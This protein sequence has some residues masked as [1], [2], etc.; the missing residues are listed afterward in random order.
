MSEFIANIKARLNTSEIP[1]DIK[2]IEGQPVKLNNVT[3]DPT[4]ISSMVKQIQA[5]LNNAKFSLP[6]LSPQMQQQGA[7]SGKQFANAFTSQLNTIAIKNNG[8]IGITKALQDFGYDTKSISSITKKLQDLDVAT[9][10]LQIRARGNGLMD[11]RIKGVDELGRS[12][13]ETRRFVNG[14]EDAERRVTST[15]QKFGASASQLKTMGKI[16]FGIE[17]NSFKAEIDSIVQDAHKLTTVSQDIDYNRYELQK[18]FNTMTNKGE[19]IDVRIEAYERFNQLLPIV[20][21]QLIDAANAEQTLTQ[22]STKILQIKEWMEKNSAATE[23][24]GNELNSIL[25]KLNGNSDS[26]VLKDVDT[27]FRNIQ[28]QAEALKTSVSSVSQVNAALSN[29]SV[30][31]SISDTEQKFRSLQST[32]NSLNSSSIG[33]GIKINVT[34]IE[35]QFKE[36]AR[37]SA[38]LSGGKLSDSAMVTK[39]NELQSVL[40]AVRNNISITANDVSKLADKERDAATAAETLS[41]STTLLSQVQSWSDNNAVAAEHFRRE[42]DE[43]TNKLHGNSDPALLKN[44][45]LQFNEIKAK[46]KELELDTISLKRVMSDLDG[47]TT[48]VSKIAKSISDA[49]TKFQ[50]LKTTIS[51]FKSAK[52]DSGIESQITG[53]TNGLTRV[54]ELQAELNSGKLT[55]A[56]MVSKYSEL[57]STLSGVNNSIS[58]LKP[59][60]DGLAQSERES[61]KATEQAAKANQTLARSETLSNKIEA[62]MNANTEAAKRYGTQLQAIQQQLKNNQDPEVLKRMTLEFSKIQSEAKAAG[63]VVNNFASS[64]KNTALQVL[65]LTSAVA[66]FHRG[67][68]V[69]K[70]MVQNVK[71]V[72]KAMTELYRVTNLSSSQYEVLYDKMANSAKKYGATLS[73]I[74]NSTASWVRLGFSADKAAQLSEISAMYQHVTDLDEGTAVKNLVTAYKGFQDS[75]LSQ[76]GGNEVEAFKTISDVYDRLGKI[77]P[78]TNYIG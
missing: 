2:K 50:A 75:L 63:L 23:V 68:R 65:G 41:K 32:I 60:I 73:D 61:A 77:L 11:V 44:L 12:V 43:I 55:P 56:Q 58:T 20:K 22:S 34:G 39:Y 59:Q 14:I 74:I 24:F 1:N 47:G 17:T 27:Q 66:I 7:N 51:S 28:V 42:L 76:T 64:L 54:K 15:V 10:Q 3:I 37:L 25:A 5:G 69:L 13:D 18:A 36:I 48:G 78:M 8:I 21:A 16:E 53:I 35:S 67:V 72:D 30:A 49:D 19:G 29:N 9:G 62:W 31:K 70:E 57:Q 38:E 40:A 4:A 46:A 71:D 33:Q 26:K 45:S 52:T 6:N